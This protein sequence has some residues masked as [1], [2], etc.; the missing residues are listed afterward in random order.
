MNPPD[1][2]A[3]I[4]HGIGHSR[5]PQI[6]ALF[7]RQ[8]AQALEY[9][10]IDVAGAEL[11]A[12]AHDFFAAGGRGL[13]VTVPHKQAVLPLCDE[14][15]ERA[16]RA[17][18]VN[19]MARDARGQVLGDNTDGAGLVRDLGTNLGVT[20]RGARVLLLG[21]GGAARG[22]LAPLL[23]AGVAGVIIA[24]RH[25]ERARQ[26][27]SE[28]NDLGTISVA[29]AEGPG[30]DAPVG[31][32]INATSASLHGALPALPAGALGTQTLCY[33]MAYGADDTVFVR[34]ARAAGAARAVGGLGMLVEQAAESFLLW[35]G[36]RPNTA[37]VLAALTAGS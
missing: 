32:V 26:L 2:Y 22:A 28:F 7:A 27:A 4:G 30:L 31:L 1:R 10:L 24:N 15:T 18:A 9:G 23:A 37:P 17:G 8:T 3:V 29:T 6:H 11:V 36:V 20:L 12:A 14:L 35:R 34:W 13:N 25:G 5:S 16:R 21:A 19:T 33:D